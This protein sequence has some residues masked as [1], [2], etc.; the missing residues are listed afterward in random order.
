VPRAHSWPNREPTHFDVLSGRQRQLAVIM[1]LS[2][3][4][5]FQRWRAWRARCW[6]RR[7]Q[8]DQCSRWAGLTGAGSEWAEH[9]PKASDKS[10]GALAP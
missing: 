5:Q 10:V 8:V 6:W 1:V 9:G 3:R 2:R 4:R 7:C